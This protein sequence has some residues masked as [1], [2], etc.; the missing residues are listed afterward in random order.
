VGDYQGG[1]G[2]REEAR[3]KRKDPRWLEPLVQL[4]RSR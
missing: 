2:S 3:V 1:G 4:R